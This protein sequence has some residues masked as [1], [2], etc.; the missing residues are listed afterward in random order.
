MSLKAKMK[1][2]RMETS[3]SVCT[4]TSSANCDRVFSKL[5]DFFTGYLKNA[6]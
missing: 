6:H 5:K 2:L 1:I 3:K 4:P